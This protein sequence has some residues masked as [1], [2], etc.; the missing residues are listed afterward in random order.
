MIPDYSGHPQNTFVYGERWDRVFKPVKNPDDFCSF[1]K[2]K[3]ENNG[4]GEN[5]P[6][7]QE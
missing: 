3:E 5:K 1:G 7:T 6:H 2:R 4:D